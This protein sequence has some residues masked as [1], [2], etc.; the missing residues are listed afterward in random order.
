LPVSNTPPPLLNILPCVQFLYSFNN[1]SSFLE[2]VNS[3]KD[4]GVTITSNL[5]YTD[6]CDR[7]LSRANQQLGM[8]RRNCYFVTDVRRRRTLYLALVR[9][10]FENCSII[11]RPSTKTL[12]SKFESIQKKAVKWILNEESLSFSSFSTYL[13]KCKEVNLLPLS[14]K[15]EL[16]DLLF[17]YK[18]IQ[19]IVPVELPDYLSFFNGQSRLRSCHLDNLS[20]VSSVTP[21]T[22]TNVFAKSFFY[23]THC[24]WNK[25]PLEIRSIESL[26]L[27]KAAVVKHLWDDFLWDPDMD[28]QDDFD[29]VLENG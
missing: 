24:K 28:L 5:D 8:I 26:D 25:L 11:W 16:N 4:L 7:L 23:S 6:Q 19:K 12:S 20:L 10:Q 18:I 3:E 13:M 2:Y 15:F 27:F 1:E 29:I 21:R 17:L 22:P 9:S 14:A